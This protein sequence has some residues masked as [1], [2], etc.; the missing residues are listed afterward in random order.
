MLHKT[1]DTSKNG[2]IFYAVK[3]MHHTLMYSKF[4]T[5]FFVFTCYTVLYMQY[6]ANQ[7]A[8]VCCFKVI[9]VYNR[10]YLLLHQCFRSA[11]ASTSNSA[12]A[13]RP[14]K[15]AQSVCAK[16]SLRRLALPKTICQQYFKCVASSLQKIMR[17]TRKLESG[18]S[19]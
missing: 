14:H 15:A 18:S 17:G 2:N 13:D 11:T 19:K 8:Q 1:I 6:S 10:L 7:C 16:N 5:Y 9:C 4:Q 3:H 12:V